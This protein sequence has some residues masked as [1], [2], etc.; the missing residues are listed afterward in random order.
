ML[1]A[2]RV[3]LVIDCCIGIDTKSPPDGFALSMWLSAS[4]LSSN[5]EVTQ[6]EGRGFL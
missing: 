3:D 1:C 5:S 4:G 6:L 2:G